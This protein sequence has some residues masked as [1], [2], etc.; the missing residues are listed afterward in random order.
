MRRPLSFLGCGCCLTK[1]DVQ[2]YPSWLPWRGSGG[3]WPGHETG[4][5]LT[6]FTERSPIESG[7]AAVYET[8]IAPR[9]NDL[10]QERKAVLAT[11]K[12]HA[13]IALAAGAALGLIFLLFG[14]GSDGLAGA[15]VGF[16]VPLAFGGVAAF[17]LWRRQAERWSAS[18]AR[19]VMPFVCDF[20]GDLS[21]DRDALKGFPLERMQKLG[22]IRPFSRSEVSDRLEGTYR[23]VPFEIVEAKLINDK[24]KSTTNTDNSASDSSSRTQFK[25]LLI[26][27]GVPEPIPGRILIARDYGMG[28]KLMSLFGSAGR[29]LPRV[30]TG[31][32]AFEDLFEVHSDDPNAAQKVLPPAFLDSFVKIAEAEG[33][34]RG[35]KSLEAGFHDDS[36]FMALQRD[37]DFLAMGKLTMPADEIEN[38]LHGVF[39]DI[40]TV[41]RIIDR[42]HGDHPEG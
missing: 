10:E 1:F 42:L 27:I 3:I 40:A 36:F 8:R 33:G 9:L 25:G 24:R 11:A 18:A 28:N 13:V 39:D 17:L 34:R 26:R 38:D 29:D 5:T 4:G 19:A 2:R 12:R 14:S 37:E 15:L 32:G 16:G 31:H 7:F 30:E 20:L 35:A 22:V 41:R 21:F 23:D 6:N